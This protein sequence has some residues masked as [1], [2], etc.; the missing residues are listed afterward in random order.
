MATSP[1]DAYIGVIYNALTEDKTNEEIVAE[2]KTLGVETS[3]ASIRRCIRRNES[4]QEAYEARELRRIEQQAAQSGA[5]PEGSSES[6]DEATYTS[7]VVTN[8]ALTEEDMIRIYQIDMERWEVERLKV[9]SWPGPIGDGQVTRYFQTTLSLKKRVPISIL[10]PAYEPLTKPYERK[11]LTDQVGQITTVIETDPH[12]PFV[13][14]ELNELAVR[15]INY[16]QPDRWV[17][18][19]DIMNLGYIGRHRDNPKWDD[20]VNEAKQTAFEYLYYR[21]EACPDMEMWLLPGNHDDRIRNEQLERNERLY[22]VT[23]AHYPGEKEGP[24]VYSLG[25]LLRL[26][27]LG[28]HY[29]EPDGTYEFEAVELAPLLAVRHGHKL[30]ASKTAPLNTAMDLGHSVIL[31]HSHNQSATAKTIW[32]KISNEHTVRWAIEAGCE[33]LYDEGMGF[34]KAGAP[35]WQPGFVTVTTWPDGHFTFDFAQYIDEKL[36]WRDQCFSL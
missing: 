17:L 35:D 24:R 11:L 26:D 1:L 23:Q 30:N 10:L 19:G 18:G 27:D 3:E 31:G 13:L 34:N 33:C 8:K 15:F 22:G 21:R 29:S 9:N 32:N 36:Y 6:E 2:L 12:C 4:L 5:E 16:L 28:I 20:T 14:E 25:H 7:Y